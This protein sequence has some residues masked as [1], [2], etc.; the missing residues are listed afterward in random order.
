MIKYGKTLKCS[1]CGCS[2]VGEERHK[3]LKRSGKDVSY[4]YYHCCQAKGKCDLGWFDEQ[5]ID[6]YFD[7]AFSALEEL[8]ITPDIYEKARKKLDEDYRVILEQSQGE[9]LALT[10]ERSQLEAKGNTLNN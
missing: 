7:W 8:T 4:V 5:E 10:K 1:L 9:L 2:I 6:R 3:K